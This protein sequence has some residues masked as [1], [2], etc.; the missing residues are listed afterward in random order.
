MI[1]KG[2]LKSILQVCVPKGF[3]THCFDIDVRFLGSMC[4]ERTYRGRIHKNVKRKGLRG[5]GR[6][7]RAGRRETRVPVLR[8]EAAKNHLTFPFSL[9]DLLQSLWRPNSGST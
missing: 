3:E 8:L 7:R 1:Q 6:K 4:A 5:E 9:P 2:L